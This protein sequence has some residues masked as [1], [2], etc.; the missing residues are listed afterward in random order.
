MRPINVPP[1]IS[2]HQK[3]INWFLENSVSIKQKLKALE[4]SKIDVSIVIPAYNEQ[5]SIMSTI[6][7]ISESVSDFGIEVIVVDNNSSDLTKEYIIA[8]GAKYLFEKVPGVEM[9]RTAGLNFA[10]GKY[11]ISADAD[12]IYSPYWVSELVKPLHSNNS[13]AI[14]YGRFAFTPEYYNR[15]TLYVYELIGDLFKSI[16]ALSKDKAMYVYGCSSAYRREQGLSVNGYE[17][18]DGVNE[19]GY[20]AVKLRNKFGKMHKVASKRSYSWTSSRK[21]LADGSL[22]QRVKKKFKSFFFRDY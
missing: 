19:D 14:S 10:S 15:F 5:E 17:H 2:A 8:T 18:P 11:V 20:L 3:S 4:K 12:T 1:Y 22:F 16:N 21:F 9:A 7:S 13:I 6:S